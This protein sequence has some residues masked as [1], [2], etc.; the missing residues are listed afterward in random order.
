MGMT[1]DPWQARFLCSADKRQSL[2]CSRQAGK[3][4]VT[5]AYLLKSALLDPGDYLVFSPT[6]R[7]SME[8]SRKVGVFFRAL[9]RPV[10]AV[11][12]NKTV[13]ELANGSRVISLPDSHEGVVG[14]TPRGIVIDEASRVS[15]ELYFS[16]RPMLAASRGW[17]CTLS[18][19][20]GNRGWFFN[21]WDDSAEGV[22][23]R[24][25]LNEQWRRTPVT[26][27]EVPRITPEFLADERLELGDRWYRQEFE[28]AFLDS[29]DAVF[30]QDVIQAARTTGI[31]PLF[32][33][34][35]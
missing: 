28:L 30:A 29:I 26:A 25:Q 6:L 9:G 5:A 35:T 34:A 32:G 19:P 1:P 15:D 33:A 4:T 16:V 27:Y 7:Q 2:L 24:E 12:S 11:S 21:I 8:L 14:F 13:L 20:F 3:S 18:T 23:R 17:L 31:E 10:P 22:L